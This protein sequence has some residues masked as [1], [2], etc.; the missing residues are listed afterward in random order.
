MITV[1]LM[2]LPPAARAQTAADAPVSAAAPAGTAAA[3]SA[4][5]ASPEAATPM[6]TPSSPVPATELTLPRDLSPW[7]MFMAADIVVKAVMIGLA[8]ASVLSWTIWFGKAIELDG[9]APPHAPC[10]RRA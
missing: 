9:R 5:P 8:F 6:A 2:M 7:G 10:H 1:S 3:T 4:A